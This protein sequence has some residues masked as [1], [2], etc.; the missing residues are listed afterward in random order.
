MS[1]K[2]LK[3]VGLLL[4]ILGGGS[5]CQLFSNAQRIRLSPSIDARIPVDA[6]IGCDTQEDFKDLK[7]L[8]HGKNLQWLCDD[9]RRFPGVFF[10]RAELGRR[11]WFMSKGP[12]DIQ[13]KPD[14]YF[15]FNYVVEGYNRRRGLLYED[16]KLGDLYCS[17]Y[18][19]PEVQNPTNV[20]VNVLGFYSREPIGW[21]AYRQ[22]DRIASSV[23]IRKSN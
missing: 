8:F 16:M 13:L 9:S 14:S 12:M 17:R 3:V 6:S 5:G 19:F 15:N 10:Y 22:M 2:H 20:V 1:I 18:F 21:K 23:R 4:W 11:P 7:V